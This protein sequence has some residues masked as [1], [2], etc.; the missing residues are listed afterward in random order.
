[1]H[2]EI[3]LGN[4]Y[5]NQVKSPIGEIV[6]NIN[7]RTQQAGQTKIMVGATILFAAVAVGLAPIWVAGLILIAGLTVI[8][9]TE[10]DRHHHKTTTLAYSLDE[11]MKVRFSAI[12]RAF[13]TLS[14]SEKIW[15]EEN[16]QAVRDRHK[17]AGASHSVNFSS[18]PIKIASS[19]P[20]FI[21]TNLTV[22]SIHI[23]DVALFFLPDYILLWRRKLYSAISYSTVSIQFERERINLRGVIPKDARLTGHTWQNLQQDGTPDT[24]INNSRLIQVEYGLLTLIATIGISL[25][26][27]VSNVMVAEQFADL[28]QSVQHW[29]SPQTPHE[30]DATSQNENSTNAAQPPIAP[31]NRKSAH[32]ILGI[33]PDASL[34]EIRAAYHRLAQMNHPD[35]V[36]GLAP[37]FQILAERRMKVITAAYKALSERVRSR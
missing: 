8:G 4:G 16:R 34:A 5:A 24:R 21:N 23:N 11:E 2:F 33:H 32:E 27:H 25:K 3:K 28:F 7:S 14:T 26:L 19:H 20:P 13:R 9:F 37:E 18:A 10:R 35:K 1:M 31:R 12:Q 22:W 15:L 17:N 36:V 29:L 30:P 6:A